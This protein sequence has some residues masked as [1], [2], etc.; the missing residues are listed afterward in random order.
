MCV[1]SANAIRSADIEQ[2]T[3]N[4]QEF[5]CVAVVGWGKDV[6]VGFVE[7]IFI[8]VDTLELIP[9]DIP[10]DVLQCMRSTSNTD[11]IRLANNG[12]Q[13][14]SQQSDAPGVGPNICK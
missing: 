4:D 3:I 5:S 14:L 13:A 1:A 2:Q 10:A 11:T 9:S 12:D 6:T 7:Y 8:A